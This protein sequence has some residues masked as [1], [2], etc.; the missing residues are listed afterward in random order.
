M[1]YL[2]SYIQ[3]VSKLPEEIF[4]GE[5][6]NILK[7]ARIMAEVC[8]KGKLIHIFG[9]GAHSSMA[10]EEFFLRPGSLMN[11]NP[12]FDPGLSVTHGAS[13]SWMIEKLKGYAKP[14]LDYYKLTPGDVMIIANSYGI[15]CLTIDA[16]M[17]AKRKGLTVIALTSKEFADSVPKDFPSRHPNKKSLYELEELDL[18]I[19]LHVP[20]GDCLI[21]IPGMVQKM[22]PVSTICLSIA[23]A[24]LNAVTIK[25]LHDK[26][27]EPDMIKSPYIV[28]DGSQN[29]EKM[30][31][32]YYEIIKHL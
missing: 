10:G 26:G 6:A 13:R 29:N 23:L 2:D 28:K 30:I 20:A 27:I 8:E 17:E 31:D 25:I 12:I 19:D 1:E 4:E 32:K 22:G 11:I 16:A 9:T 7:A 3:S 18:V 24:L 15:N 5:K 21:Q 14:I